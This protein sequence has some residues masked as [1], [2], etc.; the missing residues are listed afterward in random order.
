MENFLPALLIIGAAI[1][2]IYQEYQKEQEKA[3]KRTPTAT[4][5]PTAPAPRHATQ[6]VKP[7]YKQ[8]SPQF[9]TIKETHAN[10]VAQAKLQQK[11]IRNPLKQEVKPPIIEDKVENHNRP[12]FNLREAIIQ[13]AVLRRPY[14]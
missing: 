13:E 5:M 3:R 4:A 7:M 1:Y 10:Y 12:V 8:E 6:P 9:E 14:Q 11:D 2:K